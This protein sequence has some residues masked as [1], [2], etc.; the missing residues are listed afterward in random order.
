MVTHD[1]RHFYAS[2]FIGGGASVKQVQL[3][4]GRASAVI[5]WRIYVHLW[6]AEKATAPGPAGAPVWSPA[7]RVRPE[8][9]ACG[10]T[11]GQAA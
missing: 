11:A 6:P 9:A 7:G 3:V 1:L 8:S 10:V 4:L 5:T 2:A